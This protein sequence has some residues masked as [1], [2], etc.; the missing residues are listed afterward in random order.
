MA[1]PFP[2]PNPPSTCDTNPNPVTGFSSEAQDSTTFIGIAWNGNPPP[3][4]KP[5][6][7]VPCEAIAESQVSQADADRIAQNTAVVCASQCAGSFSNTAQT[8][9]R[10][11]VV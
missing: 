9:D 11:S 4:N 3:L 1:G 8:A 2:C 6:N 5:F 7:L 10:K